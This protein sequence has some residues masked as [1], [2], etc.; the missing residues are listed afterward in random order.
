MKYNIHIDQVRS[1]EW[2][3]NL[4]EAAAFSFCYSVPSWATAITLDG[5]IW[6]HASRNKA[7]EEYPILTLIPDTMYRH[8]RKLA[9][10]DLIA[11]RKHG[12]MDLIQITEKGREW[13]S[14]KNPN[15]EI[16]TEDIRKKIRIEAEKLGKKS[17]SATENSEKNPTNNRTTSDPVTSKEHTVPA[18]KSAGSQ[19]PKKLNWS[20]ESYRIF[21]QVQEHETGAAGLNY[22]GF[23]WNVNSEENARQMKNLRLTLI[24]GMNAKLTLPADTEPAFTDYAAALEL[25]LTWAWRYYYKQQEL[26][27]VINYTPTA[28]YRDFNKI[29]TYAASNKNRT[30][31]ATSESSPFF[32]G[33]GG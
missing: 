27:G 23:D 1:I 22:I 11:Y 15:L 30:R 14:E 12:K 7:I 2:G 32:Q 13:N 20:K 21:D 5:E 17:E 4:H 6:Y 8:Y 10:T 24:R 31:S 18:E 3:L 29:K 25:Y 33:F 9:A 28:C 16:G 19:K 26:T